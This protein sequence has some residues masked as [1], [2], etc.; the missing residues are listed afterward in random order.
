MGVEENAEQVELNSFCNSHKLQWRA[1]DTSVNTSSLKV[2]QHK[3]AC[4]R[5]TSANGGQEFGDMP[6]D[7]L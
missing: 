3:A 7:T 2:V 1:I 4:R 5:F 6:V